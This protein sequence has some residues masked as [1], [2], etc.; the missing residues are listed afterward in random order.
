MIEHSAYP[1][2]WPAGW[3]RTPANLRERG[4]FDGTPDRVRR[5][6]LHSIDR[7]ALGKRASTH[8]IRSFVVISTN[9][10]LRVDGEPRAGDRPPE[11]PGVAVYFKRENQPLCFACDKYDAVWKNMRAIQ[12]TIEALRGIER[13]GSSTLLERAFTGF[14]A[15]PERT[16]PSCW[17]ILKVPPEA[18]E[19]DVMNAWRSLAQFCH[20]DKPTGSHEKMSALNDAKDIALSTIRSR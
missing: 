15:L 11:D 12:R 17:E 16:G 2:Q 18:T 1:L 8:T 13:W 19:Q 9:M 5:E 14:A 7:I 10:R 3:K 4:Q 20:P 6:L